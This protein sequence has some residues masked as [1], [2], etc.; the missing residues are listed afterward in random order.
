METRESFYRKYVFTF[1]Y[2]FFKLLFSSECDSQN[3]CRDNIDHEIFMKINKD[4]PNKKVKGEGGTSC[5]AMANLAD[6]LT[7]RRKRN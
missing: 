6:K 4:P 3:Y 2:F 7:H 1:S 5:D